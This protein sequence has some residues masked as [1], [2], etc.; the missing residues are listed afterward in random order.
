MICCET[1]MLLRSHP[2]IAISPIGFRHYNTNIYREVP[3]FDI[4]AAESTFAV[5]S[6]AVLVVAVLISACCRSGCRRSYLDKFR[7]GTITKQVYR[8]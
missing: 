2:I 8:I 7:Y 4:M 3:F 1:T 6:A 5:S